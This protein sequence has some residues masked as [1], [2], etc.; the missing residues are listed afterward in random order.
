VEKAFHVLVV[1]AC[2]EFLSVCGITGSLIN[3]P[4]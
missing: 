2:S 1:L 4:K 3:Y